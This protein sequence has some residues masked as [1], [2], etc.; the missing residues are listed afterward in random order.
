MPTVTQQYCSNISP[1]ISGSDVNVRILTAACLQAK[2]G[3][4]DYAWGNMEVF[5]PAKLVATMGRG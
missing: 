5:G 2:R 3:Q 1:M 4:L